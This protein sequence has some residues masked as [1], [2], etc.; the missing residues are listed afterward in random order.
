[1]PDSKGTR[2]RAKCAVHFALFSRFLSRH[3]RH[4]CSAFARHSR[5][6]LSRFQTQPKVTVMQDGE[7]SLTITKEADILC[8]RMHA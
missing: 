1:M 7:I 6:S 4:L 3:P 2:G 8:G 5:F